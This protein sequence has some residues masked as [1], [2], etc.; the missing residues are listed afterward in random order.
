DMSTYYRKAPRG[1][2][3]IQDIAAM[4]YPKVPDAGVVAA[5]TDQSTWHF[6]GEREAEGLPFDP[7]AMQEKAEGAFKLKL[8]GDYILALKPVGTLDPA[9]WTGSNP[10][11]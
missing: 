9:D 2:A 7:V 6:W 4:S 11:E 8:D 3:D 10:G 5:R 1:L